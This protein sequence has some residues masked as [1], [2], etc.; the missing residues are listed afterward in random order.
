MDGGELEVKNGP[1]GEAEPDQDIE[2]LA[3]GRWL[4]HAFFRT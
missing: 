4:M 3:S 2:E 1:Q